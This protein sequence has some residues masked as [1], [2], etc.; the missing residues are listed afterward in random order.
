MKHFMHLLH[1][2]LIYDLISFITAFIKTHTIRFC[3][4]S[5]FNSFYLTRQYVEEKSFDN[6]KTPICQ[7]RN[8]MVRRKLSKIQ[9]NSAPTAKK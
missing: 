2:Q 5:L 7:T 8:N 3:L 9:N 1:L 4:G 6:S